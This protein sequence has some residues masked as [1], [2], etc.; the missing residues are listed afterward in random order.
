MQDAAP[1]F[2]PKQLIEGSVSLRMDLLEQVVWG[3]TPRPRSQTVG[4]H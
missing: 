2:W 4:P 1:V 3:E